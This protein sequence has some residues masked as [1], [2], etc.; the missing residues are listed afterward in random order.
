MANRIVRMAGLA[1]RRA[2]DLC[3]TIL[4]AAIGKLAAAANGKEQTER[5]DQKLL[6]V[7]KMVDLMGFGILASHQ[8]NVRQTCHCG[9]TLGATLKVTPI[10]SACAIEIS[11]DIAAPTVPKY[12]AVSLAAVATAPP[13][14]QDP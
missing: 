12:T 9:I 13:D 3:A 5:Q 4:A 10:Q 2:Q 1:G 11:T 6:T 14:C 7:S 8:F